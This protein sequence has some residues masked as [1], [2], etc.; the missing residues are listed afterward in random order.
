MKAAGA[1]AGVLRSG[2]GVVK[3]RALSVTLAGRFEE[4][5]PCSSPANVWLAR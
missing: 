3:Q 2:G 5:G 1:A 4:E